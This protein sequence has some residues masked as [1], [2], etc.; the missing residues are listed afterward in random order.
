MLF[1]IEAKVH[2]KVAGIS[3]PFQ[4]TYV[5]LVHA[6][7]VADAKI[8]FENHIRQVKAHA[9]PEKLTFEYVKLGDELL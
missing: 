2:V 5:K 3:G 6:N 4:E 8:K 1:Y 9:M 7:K